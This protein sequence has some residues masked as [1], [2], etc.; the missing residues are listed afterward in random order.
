MNGIAKQALK[1]W[2]IML[3]S[4][5]GGLSLIGILLGL[6]GQAGAQ[7]PQNAAYLPAVYYPSTP[8]GSYTCLEYEFGLIW[9]TETIT[10]YEDGRSVYAYGSPGGDTLTGTWVFTPALSTVAFTGFR[11]PTAT[12]QFPARLYASRYLDHV[13]FEIALAC[14]RN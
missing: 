14:R 3:L 1:R 11:W 8:A 12:Y 5:A 6:A 7:S 9:A 4:L 2:F 10:L 13:D